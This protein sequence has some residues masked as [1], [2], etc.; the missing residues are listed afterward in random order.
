MPTNYYWWGVFYRKSAFQEWG[1]Q[2]RHH[3]GR[4]HRRCARRSRAR[5]STPLTNGTG[6]TPWMASGWF[7]YLNLRINGAEFHRELL[8]GQALLRQHPR[9]RP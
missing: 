6:S 9:S 7:D 8:A 3:L 2:I 4:V 5:A 1:V